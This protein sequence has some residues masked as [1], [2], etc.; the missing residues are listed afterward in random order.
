MLRLAIILSLM[1]K[2]FRAKVVITAPL[3]YQLE[4]N[5][6][7]SWRLQADEMKLT[8]KSWIISNATRI[9]NDGQRFSG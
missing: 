5:G 2:R 6:Q 1:E 8:N 7:L 9:Q 3:I 4:P